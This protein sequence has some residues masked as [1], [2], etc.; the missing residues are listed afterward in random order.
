M[1]VLMSNWSQV[2]ELMPANYIF[3]LGKSPGKH[4]FPVFKN[5]PLIDLEETKDRHRRDI[6]HQIFSASQEF[7]IF[8]VINHGIPTSLMDDAMSVSKEFFATPAEYKTS[9]YSTDIAT[10]CKIFS[11]TLNYDNE[12]VHYWRDSFSHYCHPLQDQIHLWPDNPPRYREV[13]GQYSVEARRLLLMILELIS[14]GLGLKPGYFD[15]ELSERQVFSVNHHIPCPNPS[16]ALGMPEHSDPNLISLV[17]QCCVPGLQ[18]FHHGQWMD[19]E[20]MPH[21]FLVFPALQLKV[22]SNGKFLSPSH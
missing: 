21:A 2:V 16:L 20:P 3:P 11:S 1:D 12:E 7:G 15:G 14:E 5:I 19:V 10:K 4:V 17:Q 9:F 13:V 8:Q 6:I 22:I 18:V